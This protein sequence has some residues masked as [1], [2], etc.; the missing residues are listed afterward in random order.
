MVNDLYI[1]VKCQKADSKEHKRSACLKPAIFH[2][3]DKML[4]KYG[5]PNS[6]MGHLE[7]MEKAWEIVLGWTRL[8]PASAIDLRRFRGAP[9]EEDDEDAGD[10]KRCAEY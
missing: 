4:K 6:T 1:E 5:R 10:F 8:Q 9:I 7:Q 3:M 2:K